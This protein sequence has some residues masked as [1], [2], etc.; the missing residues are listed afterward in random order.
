LPA[1][2][3]AWFVMETVDELDL[4]PFYAPYRLDGHGRAALEPSMMVSLLLYA[5]AIGVRSARAIE[6]RCREDVA[7]E[8][9]SGR[10]LQAR[11]ITERRPDNPGRST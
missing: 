8:G 5:Y 3:L 7:A 2:H 11:E 1:D 4:E 10:E 6:R 9:R